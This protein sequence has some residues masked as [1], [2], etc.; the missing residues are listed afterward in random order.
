MVVIDYISN[1]L[2]DTK[3]IDINDYLFI[4]SKKVKNISKPYHLCRNTN[5]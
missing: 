4:Y 5:Y 3:P 2:I 1:R